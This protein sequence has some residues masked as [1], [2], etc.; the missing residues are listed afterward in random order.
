MHERLFEH[1]SGHAGVRFTTFEDIADDFARRY[2][3][4]GSARPAS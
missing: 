1:I 2:P 4:S 3:R